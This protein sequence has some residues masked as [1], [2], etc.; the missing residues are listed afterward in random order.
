VTVQHVRHQLFIG[1]T[2]GRVIYCGLFDYTQY[3]S[4]Q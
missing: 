4:L 1:K 3:L 2:I